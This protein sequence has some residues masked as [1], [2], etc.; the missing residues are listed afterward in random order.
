MGR[1]KRRFE[2]KISAFLRDLGRIAAS[3]FPHTLKKLVI[4][5][6]DN[7]E[8]AEVCRNEGSPNHYNKYFFDSFLLLKDTS[9]MDDS[10]KM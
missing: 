8:L 10:K 3:S 4:P 2:T 1:K 6:S 7:P 9:A 5:H